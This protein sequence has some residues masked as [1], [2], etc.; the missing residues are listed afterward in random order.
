MLIGL[1]VFLLIAPSLSKH[2]S[3]HSGISFQ[4]TYLSLMFFSIWSLKNNKRW[5]Y[6]G[7]GLIII[8]IVVAIYNAY[9]GSVKSQ[10]LNLFPLL[11]FCILSVIVAMKQVLFSGP[12]TLNKLIGSICIY[13]LIGLIWA[14][15]YLSVDLLTINTFAGISEGS[16]AHIWTYVYFSFV[17]LSTLGFGDIV[18]INELARSLVYLEAI[19]GQ[20][21]LTILVASLVGGYITEHSNSNPP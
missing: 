11:I 18:P 2:F 13:F 3:N 19:S 7:I 9:L 10:L 1:L 16:S 8:S 12:I 20:I 4:L 15:L 17:T 14:L 6:L 5:F 21:Y